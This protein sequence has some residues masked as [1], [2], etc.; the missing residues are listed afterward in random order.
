[1]R[2]IRPIL[3]VAVAA[4]LAGCSGMSSTQTAL[5][6]TNDAR[7]FEGT[8]AQLQWR[9]ISLGARSFVA[10]AVSGYRKSWM[11]PEAMKQSQL[12][13][14]ADESAG[15]VDVFSYPGGKPEGVLTG[16]SDPAG[17]CTN[18]GGDVYIL[19]G[20]GMTA[21]V[22]A[23]GGSSPLRTL[24]LSGYPEL[25][26]TVDQSTGDFAVGILSSTAAIVVFKHGKGVP[27][28]YQPSG[29]NGIPGC[30]Y[31]AHGNLYCD[32][33]SSS[34]SSFLLLELPKNSSMVGSIPVSGT[35]GLTAGPMQWDGK[36]LAFGAGAGGTIYQIALKGA[37]GSVKGHT[38]LSGAGDVWQFWI[39]G[40]RI[41]VPTYGG[42][43]PAEIGY[44]KY[45]AGGS[46]TKSITG[47]SQPDGATISTV[48]N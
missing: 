8:P 20:G 28:I 12:L 35:T 1:M 19:N 25:N 7:T 17:M 37:S 23:H 32:A 3:V 31:D 9:G 10:P 48:K 40:K 36:D 6:P 24:N 47:L 27:T 46:A 21:E 44:F 34:N 5:A 39:A 42:S 22:F 30:T 18:K 41:I 2:S 43:D 13:Y 29:E 16:F 11:L 4:A 14:A 33:Y 45:P 15:D 26:C 38:T